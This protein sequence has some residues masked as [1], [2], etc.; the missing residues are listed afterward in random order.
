MSFNEENSD[1]IISDLKTKI[2][3][4]KNS[5]LND[6]KDNEKLDEFVVNRDMLQIFKKSKI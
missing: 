5:K 4:I 1:N 6:K 3:L 2:T